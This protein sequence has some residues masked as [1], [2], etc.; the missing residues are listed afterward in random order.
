MKKRKSPLQLQKLK[1][2]KAVKVYVKTRDGYTCQWCGKFLEGSNAH[3]SHVIPVSAGNQ[4]RY[5]PLNLKCLCY[6][7]HLNLWH[8]NPVEAG[9][10]FKEKFPE[11][12]KY[13][14]SKPRETVKFDIDQLKE[15]ELD[16][17][18]RTELLTK[19]I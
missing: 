11:R 16:F 6:H 2:E 10:W 14:F 3:A 13:L 12:H 4:F 17:I 7:C 18:Q 1:T 15:M 9:E 19:Q 8:K 5:D